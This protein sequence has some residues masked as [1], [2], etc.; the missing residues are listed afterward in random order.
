MENKRQET[1]YFFSSNRLL[2]VLAVVRDTLGREQIH[3]YPVTETIYF[4]LGSKDDYAFPHGLRIRARRYIKEL[5]S[6]V[7]IDRSPFFLEIKEE[8]HG[9]ANR[10]K[11]IETD[12]IT[13]V[14]M[15]NEIG[16]VEQLPKLV[17]YAATQSLRFHWLMAKC[18]RLT[19]DADLRLFGFRENKP[20][21]AEHVCDF[22]E[23]KLEFKIESEF[24]SPLKTQIVETVKCVEHDYLYLERRTRQCMKTWLNSEPE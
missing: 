20:L 17:T 19:L 24:Q 7:S 10:K 18:E 22:G 5:T 11:R 2:E 23:G 3:E 9:G 6:S 15:L 14:K 1:R 21:E 13:A 12:G 16:V 4:T 8:I